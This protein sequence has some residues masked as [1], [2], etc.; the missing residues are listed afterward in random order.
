[1]GSEIAHDYSLEDL[2]VQFLVLICLL[3]NPILYTSDKDDLIRLLTVME[4]Q[5]RHVSCNIVIKQESPINSPQRQARFLKSD[6][7]IRIESTEPDGRMLCVLND[8]HILRLFIPNKGNPV[9]YI[10][11]PKVTEDFGTFDLRSIIG[12]NTLY[13]TGYHPIIRIMQEEKNCRVKKKVANNQAYYVVTYSST[14]TNLS[15]IKGEQKV[16]IWYSI[17]KNGAVA[18]MNQESICDDP[19]AS[20]RDEVNFDHFDEISPGLFLPRQRKFNTT[21]FLKNKGS[22][23]GS[24]SSITTVDTIDINPKVSESDFTLTFPP[25]T[26]LADH[27]SGQAWVV[28]NDGSFS[29]KMKDGQRVILQ[30]S[31]LPTPAQNDRLPGKRVGPSASEPD[32]GAF[33]FMTAGASLI[34]LSLAYWLWQKRRQRLKEA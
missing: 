23:K 19:F 9:G 13:Q 15:G 27:I 26:D 2:F 8:R 4:E 29:P 21:M 1:M 6:K 30:K 31:K 18:M 22:I 17:D 28:L 20:S 34:I 14:A 16:E 12:L 3:A 24:Y 25:N 11:H 33:W 5:L 10:N 7:K 32:G